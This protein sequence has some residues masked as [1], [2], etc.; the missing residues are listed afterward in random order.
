VGRTKPLAEAI[1]R[2]F[3]DRPFE[4]ELWDGTRVESTRPGPTLRLR[5]PRVVGHLL[6]APGELG[7]GR[8][9][10]YGDIETDDLDG[11]IALLGRWQ[12]PSLGQLTRLRIAARA[13]R[14]A[15]LQRPPKPPAAELRPRGSRHSKE[16][17]A[18][19]V[20]HHYD[21][22]NEFFA[23]FL[24]ES[25]TYSCAL[26]EEGTE[27]LEQAQ[28]AKLD[29]ICRKLELNE[30]ERFLDIGCG[31][32]SLVIHAGREYGVSAL[33]IT[34]SE[35]QAE[36]ARV[37]ARA[38]GVSE[39]VEFKVMD[40]RD[41]GDEPFDAIA[42]IGMVE[43]VGESQIDEYA[44]LIAAALTP[45]GKVL[46]HGIVYVPPSDGA[47]HGGDFSRRYVFPDGEL[48]NLSRMASA[49]ERAGFEALHVENLHT[50]YAETLR[51]WTARFEQHLDEAE[52]LAGPERVRVWRL[53]L[54][55]A[56]NAFETGNNSV[57]QLLCSR[58]LME[59]AT[60]TPTS[61]RRAPVRRRVPTP[62]E[63]AGVA[64]S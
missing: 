42:S 50:D 27:S 54:R 28:R 60:P 6:R 15:G 48:L 41:L 32:G 9:Y 44:R 19:A 22:S 35:P 62:R 38:A 43:H 11:V 34:L 52:R 26:F 51:H 2:A 49:F 21:V 12:A 57:Y 61:E 17:D 36:L 30:G 7:L 24:D 33:G 59:R 25:M 63:G 45:D 64:A 10:V 23:L 5:S 53:Y 47:H 14:A 16:R 20:R 13:L 3:P 37:R 31:W 40:Y 18:R 56:R 29:L 39:R 1:E 46:N 58:P 55:A 4:I 8:A